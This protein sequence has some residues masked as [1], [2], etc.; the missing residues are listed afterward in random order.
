MCSSLS[1]HS[2]FTSLLFT[3]RTEDA[4]YVKVDVVRAADAEADTHISSHI[5]APGPKTVKK[6]L[7]IDEIVVCCTKTPH[8]CINLL[9]EDI[10]PISASHSSQAET[11][12]R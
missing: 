5:R 2:T 11:A 12:R 1:V 7:F 6:L 9:Q 8:I 3:K 10:Y 4:L